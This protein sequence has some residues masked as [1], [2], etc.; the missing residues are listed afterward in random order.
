MAEKFSLQARFKSFSYAFQ[1]FGPLI[2]DQHNARVHLVATIVVIVAA[3]YFSVAPLSWA[4]LVLA[5]A[6]VWMA[7][8]MNTAVEALADALMP[9][10]HPLVKV[11]KDVAAA[12]VLI[13]AAASVLIA[14]IV[15][16]S[17]VMVLLKAG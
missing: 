6:M 13:A 3:S 17:P 1:G 9:E 5:M 7:E 16:Y 14:F 2:R 11:A 8:A 15:F 4:L 10:H 12:G